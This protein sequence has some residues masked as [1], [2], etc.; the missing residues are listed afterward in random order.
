MTL[1]SK[2]SSK[3][4]SNLGRKDEMRAC[5]VTGGTGNIGHALLEA[6]LDDGW[7][8]YVLC[9]PGSA[10][11]SYIPCGCHVVPM[12]ISA[13]SGAAEAVGEPCEA[14][15]HLAWNASYGQERNDPYG[16]IRNIEATVAAVGLACELGCNVFI[17]AGSQAQYGPSDLTLTDDSPMRPQSN[18][19]AAKCCAEVMSR[20]ECA[21]R[22][23]RHIWARIFSV[24]GPCDGPYTLVTSLIRAYLQGTSLDL[25]PCGQTWD[26]LYAEDAAKALLALAE[27]G[28][29]G[30]AYC[31]ASG[32]ARPL[33]RYIEEWRMVAGE[34]AR[35]RI[36]AIPYPDG[37]PPNLN[38][39]IDKLFAHT[40][41]F[42]RIGFADGM[43]MT[44]SWYQ[45]HLEALGPWNDGTGYINQRTKGGPHALAKGSHE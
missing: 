24:Y 32:Q 38:C 20:I 21:N 45:E 23:V 3:T 42:P 33:V 39:S 25:T 41:F 44:L 26:F 12:D 13:L 22:G 35:L 8:P 34:R 5:V 40:G 30:E 6:L 15:F 16:Q 1:S 17:G 18:Y 29:D 2:L 11:T 28:R 9:H 7:R 19:G 27:K 10:R 4:V 43:R 14:F 37:K 36:G 31:V